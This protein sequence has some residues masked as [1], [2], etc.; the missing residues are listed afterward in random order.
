MVKILFPDRVVG[1]WLPVCCYRGPMIEEG[2]GGSGTTAGEGNGDGEG[3]R[4]TWGRM[5]KLWK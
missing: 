4:N 5:A 1:E 3:W 2:A